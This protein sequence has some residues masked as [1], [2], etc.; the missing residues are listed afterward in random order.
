MQKTPLELALN[1]PDQHIRLLGLRRR[2]LAVELEQ[3]DLMLRSYAD[4]IED[5]SKGLS[6]FQRA[7]QSEPKPRNPG[8]FIA[9]TRATLLEAGRPLTLDELHKA[10]W[11]R[12]PAQSPNK[13][14]SFRLNL[15][16]KREYFVLLPKRQGYWLADRPL[17]EG[18]YLADPAEVQNAA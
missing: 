2:E 12:L 7:V 4:V 17:P 16:A 11:A 5:S 9:M 1:S 10:F 18:Y 14:D 13:K 6:L 8:D 3:I 15:A